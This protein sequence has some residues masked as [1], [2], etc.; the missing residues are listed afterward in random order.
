MTDDGLP[1]SRDIAL[2][3]LDQELLLGNDAAHDVADRH[4]SD[5]VVTVHHGEMSEAVVGHELHALGDRRAAGDGHG[6]SG[7]DVCD[8]GVLRLAV[9]ED[10]LPCVIPLGNDPNEGTGI[11]DYKGS[12]VLVRHDL[13]RVEHRRRGNDA[14]DGGVLRRKELGNRLL[15]VLQDT[16]SIHR[17]QEALL[18]CTPLP[19]TYTRPIVPNTVRR[20]LMI[21]LLAG[22]AI[23]V[24]APAFAEGEAIKGKLV[25]VD[26]DERSP[27]EGVTMTVSQDGEEVGEG[28]S[29]AEGAWI[30][31]VPGAGTYQVRLDETTLPDGVAP[32]DPEKVELPAVEVKDGQEKVIIFQLGP[33][34][35]DKASTYERVGALFFAGLKLGAV[36]ALS[37]VGL[38]LIFA[39]TGLV[40]F[41]HGEMVTLG[42]VFAYFFHTSDAGPGFSLILAAIPAILLGAAVGWAQDRGIW[43]PLRRRNMGLVSMMVVSIGLSFA[44]RHIILVVFGGQ[45]RLY[46]DYTGQGPIDI[47]GIPVVPKQL[48]T[49]V[50]ALVVLGAIG[51]FLQRTKVGTALRAVSDN[52]DLAES[53]GIDVNRVISLTWILAGG[54]AALGGI[55]FG[56]NEAVQWD[57]GF[58]LLLLIFAAVV[59]GGLGT[60]YGAMLGGFVVGVAVEMSTLFVASE[61]KTAVGLGLLIVILLFRP[62]GILGSRERIG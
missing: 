42:A 46:A 62:Q 9:D 41:A 17:V 45:R 36:I 29:D 30:V 39:V 49:I 32:T 5:E 4:D 43:R 24:A 28:I 58:R 31:P 13:Q 44:L 3:L 2:E 23:V 37:A 35:V 12:D 27:V 21:V 18:N 16:N 40:N 34:N 6:I 38:S 19:T 56:L 20:L 48:V 47:L 52:V 55:F 51:L 59:L 61:L 11:D 57:M 60:A 33:G 8:G 54:L 7:H 15:H 1:S 25:A 22:L 26:G 14:P 10:D 50:V 53:S